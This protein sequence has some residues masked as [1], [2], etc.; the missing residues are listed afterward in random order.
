MDGTTTIFDVAKG[1][2][3][4]TLEGHNMPVR[5]LVFSLVDTNVFFIASDKKHIHI[6][7]AKSRVLVSAFSRHTSWVLSVDASPEGAA[8]ASGSSA[9]TMT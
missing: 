1:K 8:I 4:H 3:L 2:L 5:S 7:D 9:K 6:Y